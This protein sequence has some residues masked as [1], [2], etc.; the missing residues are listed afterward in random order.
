M[1][2]PR[3]GG[4]LFEMPAAL[5]PR[6]LE[7]RVSG[8]GKAVVGDEGD[9]NLGQELVGRSLAPQAPLQPKEGVRTGILPGHNLA[10]QEELTRGEREGHRDLRKLQS[11]VVE[12]A[13]EERDARSGLVRVSPDSVELLFDR[14]A[15]EIRDDLLGILDR[16]REHE[17]DRMKETER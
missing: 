5:L 15:R 17:S 8:A 7:E 2:A 16:A 12:R 13:R 4:D 10:V 9:G 6:H 3:R 11:D 1:E 14:E